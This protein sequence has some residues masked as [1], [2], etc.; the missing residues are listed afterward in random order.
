[1]HTMF[2]RHWSSDVCSSDLT[3]TVRAALAGDVL[4]PYT[5]P[6]ANRGKQRFSVDKQQRLSAVDRL[7]VCVNVD[8]SWFAEHDIAPPETMADLLEPAYAD[9]LAMPDPKASPHGMAFLL[10]SI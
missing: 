6:E 4:I 10:G 8:N 1:R 2:S 3:S 5:S 9:L 7:A